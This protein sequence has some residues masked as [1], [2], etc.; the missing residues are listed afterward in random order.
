MSTRSHHCG[1]AIDFLIRSATTSGRSHWGQWEA[2]SSRCSSGFLNRPLMCCAT[3]ESRFGSFRPKMIETGT[4]VVCSLPEAIPLS[5]R[6]RARG[7]SAV[8]ARIP[9]RLALASPPRRFGAHRRPSGSRGRRCSRLSMNGIGFDLRSQGFVS[10]SRGSYP[11][12]PP[13]DSCSSYWFRLCGELESCSSRSPN[14]AA[15]WR[16]NASS[17]CGGAP[18]TV[19][20]TSVTASNSPC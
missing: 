17:D 2:C 12:S 18:P 8:H 4:M 3:S 9:A 14:A 6:S 10:A 1:A 7:I 20:T 13:R 19:W 16:M 5:C 15:F 11:T